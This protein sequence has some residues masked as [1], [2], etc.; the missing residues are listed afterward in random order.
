MKKILKISIIIFIN[1]LI[2]LCLL[3]LSDYILFRIVKKDVKE[4]YGCSKF[5]Y[6]IKKDDFFEPTKGVFSNLSNNGLYGRLPDGLQ[7]KNKKPIV[8]FGCSFA[9]G[10]FL[11]Y[12]QTFS[13][14]LSN[15]LKCPVYNRALSGAGFQSMYMQVLSD[16]FYEEV[17]DSNTYIYIMIPDHY[18]RMMGNE[19]SIF[20]P[21]SYPY[22]HYKNGELVKINTDNCLLNFVRS[23]Y[24]LRLFRH[25]FIM[26][27]LKNS[28]NAQKLTDFASAYFVQTR[29]ILEKK[30]N[31]KI[32][33]YVILYG[34]VAY[35][36]LLVQKLINNNF[37]VFCTDDMTDINIWIPPYFS[38]KTNH[39]AEESWDLLTPKIAEKI[40]YSE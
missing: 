34:G 23:S 16:I 32:N 18:R 24:T 13:Y 26:H 36:D 22:F 17:P 25:R 28:K 27:Y 30:L 6:T 9:H 29:N 20:D 39:P 8:V 1:I 4:K 40:E 11:D 7:Y 31:H 10:Q 19:F 3:V 14:K 5:Q 2:L 35:Q 21:H 33:F 12:T 37:K 38:D 15:I